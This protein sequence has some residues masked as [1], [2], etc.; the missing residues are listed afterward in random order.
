M[1]RTLTAVAT[2]VVGVLALGAPA[3]AQ[4]RGEVRNDRRD[5][6]RGPR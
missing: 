3:P 1:N 2:V 5:L 6:S 4:D